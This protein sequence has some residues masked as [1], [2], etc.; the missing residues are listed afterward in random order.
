MFLFDVQD[1][2]LTMKPFTFITINVVWQSR[3]GDTFSSW[4]SSTAV[5]AIKPEK[6]LGQRARHDMHASSSSSSSSRCPVSVVRTNTSKHAEIITSSLWRSNI[7]QHQPTSRRGSCRVAGWCCCCCH[8]FFGFKQ[9]WL[10]FA[11]IINSIA[12]SLHLCTL[13]LSVSRT[14]RLTYNFDIILLLYIRQ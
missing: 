13:S 3:S 14:T 9:R 4:P 10:V 6:K 11:Y 8:H 1:V 12:L 5:A 2:G 7:S